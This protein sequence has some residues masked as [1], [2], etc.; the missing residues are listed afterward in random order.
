LEELIMDNANAY[1]VKNKVQRQVD[2]RHAQ[3]DKN[4]Q[5]QMAFIKMLNKLLEEIKKKKTLT[6]NN[7]F[8]KYNILLQVKFKA[9]SMEEKKCKLMVGCSSGH[10]PK[11]YWEG[12]QKV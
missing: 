9:L 12:L 6:K 2:Q 11:K 1:Q 10:C 3:M 7:K 8:K 4:L 5:N